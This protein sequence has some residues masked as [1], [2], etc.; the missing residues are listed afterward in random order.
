MTVTKLIT[1]SALILIGGLA[2]AGE[3]DALSV[4]GQAMTTRVA[5]Q[6]HTPNLDEVFSGWVFRTDETQ[7]LQMDDFENPGFVFVDK[8]IDLYAKVDGSKGKSCASC[9]E[10]VEAVS[11]THLRAHET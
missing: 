6:A 4:E 8:G 11:Y 3:S 9:H 2:Q 10:N 1:A 5:A 7:A